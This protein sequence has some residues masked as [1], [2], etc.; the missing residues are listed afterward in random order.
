MTDDRGDLCRCEV[1]LCQLLGVGGV[2]SSVCLLDDRTHHVGVVVAAGCRSVDRVGVC[3]DRNQRDRGRIAVGVA[4]Q[5]ILAGS[6]EG[7]PVY[8]NAACDNLCAIKC[9]FAVGRPVNVAGK[10]ASGITFGGTLVRIVG[11]W[12]LKGVTPVVAGGVSTLRT[13]LNGAHVIEDCLAIVQYGGI[14]L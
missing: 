14:I 4:V 11:K 9:R 5:L 12:H 7:F 1:I 13:V 6:G 2:S 8:L 10:G 3:G